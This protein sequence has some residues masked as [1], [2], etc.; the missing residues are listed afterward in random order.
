MATIPTATI[1]V[2]WQ[3]P[4]NGF[5]ARLIKAANRKLFVGPKMY[6]SQTLMPLG[7]T[8]VGDVF[9]RAELAYPGHLWMAGGTMGNPT[10]VYRL[11][12]TGQTI[13]KTLTLREQPFIPPVFAFDVSGNRL[14]AGYMQ[15]VEVDVVSL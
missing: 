7:Q 14:F 2:D 4:Q 13:E 1:I 11:D 8:V 10:K 6:D 5:G 9:L 15:T 12:S 3:P